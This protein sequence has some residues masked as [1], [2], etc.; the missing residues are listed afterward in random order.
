M[1]VT[2]KNNTAMKI[3]RSSETI[4]RAAS[5]AMSQSPSVSTGDRT[6]MSTWTLDA[7]HSNIEFAVRHLMISTVRGR[8][9]KLAGS[10][11]LDERN[12]ANSRVEVTIDAA[13]IDTREDQRD[14]HLRSADFFEVEKFPALTFKATGIT[15]NI[16][17]TF[18]LS[19]NL[20]I[21]GITR[22]ITLEVTS[23]GHGNDPWGNARAG[24]SARA[25]LKRSDFGLTWNQLIEAGGVAVGDE[26]S[27]GIDV[28]LVR[29]AELAIAGA[30]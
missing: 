6:T 9:A 1:D 18:R 28:E 8:F 14:T 23:E 7:S 4:T 3:S 2:E 29:Q 19:G 26:I 17:D 22:P 11:E 13:S 12:P 25:K 24:Y 20:T 15:G 21:K 16:R 27:I 5:H 10:V 30:A